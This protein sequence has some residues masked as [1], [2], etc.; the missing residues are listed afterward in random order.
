MTEEELAAIEALST[1]RHV[2]G[3][4]CVATRRTVDQLVAEVRRLRSLPV[5]ETCGACPVSASIAES[6]GPDGE[7]RGSAP[8]C[9]MA[10]DLRTTDH[11]AAPPDW[12]PLRSQR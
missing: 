11:D 1:K 12:C 4:F 6:F 10:D 7:E 5:I 2:E 3:A 9:G 8:V